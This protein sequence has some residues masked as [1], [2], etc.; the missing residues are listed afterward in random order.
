MNKKRKLKTGFT[1]MA[2]V[3]ITLAAMSLTACS[4]PSGGGGPPPGGT[5]Y[6]VGDTG[7][8]GGKIFYKSVAGFT[9][10]GY[11]GGSGSFASYTAHYLEVAPGNAADSNIV[12]GFGEGDTVIDGVSSYTNNSAVNTALSN[13][14]IGN[15]RKDTQIIIA[16]FGT[17]A[18]YA[19]RS[20]SEY[21]TTSGHTD[22][23]LPSI[24]ELRLLY[25]STSA[26]SGI[27]SG[28][29]WSSSQL[30]DT[31]GTYANTAWQLNFSSNQINPS[32]KSIFSYSVRAI[33]AF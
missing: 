7:P 24:T 30:P 20:A 27:D 13:G 18:V 2:A 5:T 21:T 25:Q 32:N 28:T 33:R 4:N 19:A 17:D 1:A 8:G 31:S 16:E 9:V 10:Q 3:I 12:W 26:V 15:G 6:E 29:F 22:W 23:F 11:S 14:E